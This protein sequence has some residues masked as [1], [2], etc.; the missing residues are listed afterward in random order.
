MG[1]MAYQITNLA[2]VYATVYSGADQDTKAPRHWPL[3]EEFTDDRWIP[4]T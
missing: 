1:T 4:R 3:W 2:I